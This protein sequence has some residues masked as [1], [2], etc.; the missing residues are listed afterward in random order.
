[1]KI[2]NEL[3]ELRK[4]EKRITSE[5]LNKLQEM[6]NSRQYLEMGYNSL[7]DYLV[8][9]LGYSEATA[10]QRQACVRLAKE[11]PELKQKI[12][13]GSLTLSAVTTA[14]KHLRKKPVEEKR[15]ILASMENKSSREV[16]AL[17]LE[18]TPTIKI[19][20]T[21]YIDKVHLRLELSHEQHEKLEKLKALKSH[22]HSVESLLLDL[23]EKELKSYE[24]V[25]G[26]PSKSREG[27]IFGAP[28]SKNPRQIS[29]RLRNDV[30]KEAHFKCQYPG[31][32][33]DHFLQ[34]DHI[35]PVRKGGNQQRQNLQVLC[36]RHNRH[37]G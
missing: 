27:K 2:H 35:F 14:F 16:T 12:D 6:E 1:M 19:K 29:K 37:K 11:V 28:K 36:A 24:F 30:L 10:Y 5:I 20:K 15:K 26:K 9:G 7:F 33:S 8:R 31:C 13:Q 17:F 22:K 18:P 23:I 25:Q 34:I 3:L 4:Q 32:E 21:E